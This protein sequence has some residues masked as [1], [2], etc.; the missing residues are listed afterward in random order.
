[1]QSDLLQRTIINLGLIMKRLSRRLNIVYL[2]YGLI[3]ILFGIAAVFQ[4]PNLDAVY[5]LNVSQLLVK[6]FLP[7]HDIQTE[8]P[9]ISFFLLAPFAAFISGAYLFTAGLTVLFI[10]LFIAARFVYLLGYYFFKEKWVAHI[11]VSVFLL[12]VYVY[13]GT[14]YVLEPFV[15]F[16]GLP[17]IW[18][19]LRSNGRTTWLLSSGVLCG[20]A[21]FTKQYGLGFLPLCFLSVLL[22]GRPITGWGG[23]WYRNMTAMCTQFGWITLGFAGVVLVY[24]GMALFFG[25][26]MAVFEGFVNQSYNDTFRAISILARTLKL[27]LAT[28]GFIFLPLFFIYRIDVRLKLFFLLCFSG[29]FGFSLALYFAP[30]AHYLILLTPFSALLF[31]GICLLARNGTF[32]FRRWIGIFLA[33]FFSILLFCVLKTAAG[34]VYFRTSDTTMVVVSRK[35]NAVIP[36]RETTLFLPNPVLDYNPILLYAGLVSPLVPIK[37]AWPTRV[38]E[39][40]KMD[41]AQLNNADNILVSRNHL[42]TVSQDPFRRN[43]LQTNFAENKSFSDEKF[44]LLS[45][46]VAVD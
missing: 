44:I 3:V 8:Y 45:R 24:F 14:M 30:Y 10:I 20:L 36:P 25:G 2:F 29:I 33:P 23:D 46:I 28:S 31:G 26:G 6:G 5:Y 42:T 15:L 11:C 32:R 34:L 37:P 41:N 4:K 12:S 43:Y 21:M 35:L 38:S 40:D 13:E 17:A 7:W 22:C 39:L 16:W 1:M 9:Y 19:V 27:F 18:C